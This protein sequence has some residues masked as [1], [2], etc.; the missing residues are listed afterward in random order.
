MRLM[1]AVVV[2]APGPPQVLQLLQRPVPEPAAGQVRLQVAFVG[3]NPIDALVRRQKLDWLPLQYPLIPGLEHSGLVDA[4]GAGVDPMWLGRRVLSR[5]SF[6]GYAD[7]SLAPI[8]SLV[9]IP[10]GLSLLQGAVYRGC[11]YTAWHA[12]H[13]VARLQPGETVLVHSAAG[14]VG[15]MAL[16]IARDHGCAVVGLCGGA[17][18]VDWL[19]DFGFDRVID[20]LQPNWPAQARG[21]V[22]ARGFDVI[23]DGN[24]GP[25]AAHNY[26]LAA[27]LGRIVYLGAMAGADAPPIPVATLVNHS[28]SVSGMTLRQ[29]E[30]APDSATDREIVAA[31]VAARWR[32]PIGERVPLAQVA[33]LHR[34]LEARQVVG[35]AVIEVGGESLGSS[36]HVKVGP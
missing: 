3:M 36:T 35:R 23:L 24:G 17:R 4:V 11:S 31:C 12:L 18:K 6:G 19:R 14:A 20:Y 33:D 9:T 7:Y 34:R 10:N 13:A 16:Q 29:I 22:G 32:L 2:E 15:C 5:V 27:R 30:A 21:M 28:I 8:T 26:P 25:N 1:R